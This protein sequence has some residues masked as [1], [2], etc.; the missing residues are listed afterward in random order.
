M[1]ELAT[2]VIDTAAVDRATAARIEAAEAAAWADLYA[3]APPDFA[4]A[5][6]LGSRVVA[7]ARVLSWK[8]SGR[9]YFSRVIGFGVTAPATEKALE[10]ILSGYQEAGIT[11]F[12]LQR[13]PQCQPPEYEAWL[14]AHGL[15]IFD[16]QDRIVRGGEP[17]AAAG[18]LARNGEVAVERVT[19]QTADEWAAFLPVRSS[20]TSRRPRQ[21]WTRPPTSTS[22]SSGS[23]GRTFVPTTEWRP[24]ARGERS[25]SLRDLPTASRIAHADLP[26]ANPMSE[27]AIDAAIA[28]LDVPVA[29]VIA[30]TGCG[31][32][33]M[34]LRAS[35]AHAGAHGVGV[36]LDADAIAEARRRAGDL[37]ARFEVRDAA[38][39][40][41]AFDAVINVASSHVHGGF[42]AALEALRALAPAV[43]YGEGFWQRAPTT[44][45]LTAL[46]GATE[47]ELA[48]IDGLR[49]A[50]GGAG[51][52]ILHESRASGSDWA[53][54]EETLAACA[55][56]H[57]G[58]DS[59]A[60]ARRIRERRAMPGGTDTLG[61]G[62]FVLR[63]C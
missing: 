46:G 53:Y 36:D 4:E 59:L 33:E 30:D 29:P 25:D 15:E 54:Y 7:G 2:T 38:T 23:R 47:D 28:A 22:P 60:Y 40:D 26:F 41:A 44:D 45:F 18:P 27:A 39:V 13:L 32:G 58:S 49:A 12:L 55:E 62:L 3:A 11:M 14:R 21:R 8:A 48:D 42:P 9:R 10:D 61:F 20:P 50:I 35:R 31:N 37:S 17:L 5:A 16:A 19:D 63:R 57:G 52:E 43:L 1:S 6:G 24:P 51:F 34:L 56:R